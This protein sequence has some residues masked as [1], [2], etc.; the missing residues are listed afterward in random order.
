MISPFPTAAEIAQFRADAE[1]GMLSTVAVRY[2]T[3]RTAQNETTG[4]EE[5]IMA[6]R[7]NSPAKF[8][9][10]GSLAANDV[11]TGGRR[12][13]ID[14]VRVDLPWNCGVVNQGDEIECL[15]SPQPRLVGRTFVVGAP[16][17]KD[18]QTATRLNVKEKP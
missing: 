10:T 2:K 7:F 14:E 18:F 8:Q 12:E 11:T 13:V 17:D 1:A 5:P 9:T 4:A 16:L 3:G 15:T 6:L